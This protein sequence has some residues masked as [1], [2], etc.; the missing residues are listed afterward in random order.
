MP[1]AFIS[2]NI[3]IRQTLWRHKP[4]RTTRLRSKQQQDSKPKLLAFWAVI[5]K[6]LM[7]PGRC[8]GD[9]IQI[10]VKMRANGRWLLL[11]LDRLHTNELVMTQELIANMLGVRREGVTDA[12][13]RLQKEGLIRYRRGQITV[14]DR[15]RLEQRTCECY[16]VVKK[17]YDRLLPS[18]T[19]AG[20]A[21]PTEG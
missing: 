15:E 21:H 11:S 14:L 20:I 5:D 3:G 18:V 13:G 10:I 9:G 16:A 2:A 8:Q 7:I 1:G 6:H 19:G 4:G 17:E 12:A